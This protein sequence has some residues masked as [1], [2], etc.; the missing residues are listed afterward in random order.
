MPQ[1]RPSLGQTGPGRLVAGGE[2]RAEGGTCRLKGGRE[3]A[4]PALVVL[5]ALSPRAVTPASRMYTSLGLHCLICEM[6]GHSQLA[7]H[8]HNPQ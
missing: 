5:S 4:R 7:G 8:L 3:E 6:G 2:G 1:T